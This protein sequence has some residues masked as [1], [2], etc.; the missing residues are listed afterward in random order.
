MKPCSPAHMPDN[1][2]IL[3]KANDSR[4]R[5]WRELRAIR[6]MLT[7]VVENLPPVSKPVS[8]EEEGKILRA[9]LARAITEPWERLATLEKAVEAMKPYISNTKD[10][11][12]YPVLFLALRSAMGKERPETERLKNLWEIGEREK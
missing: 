1:C 3:E 4:R 11:G 12:R 5:A 8:F 6:Q 7:L 2:P 9:A 10:D